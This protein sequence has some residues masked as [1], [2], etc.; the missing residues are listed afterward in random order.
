MEHVAFFRKHKYLV[1]RNLL[2]SETVAL[3]RS[4]F[5]ICRD[6]GRFS[7]DRQCPHSLSLG[8]DPGFDAVLA[9]LCPKI[10]DLTGTTLAPTYS[11]TRIYGKGE[12]LTRHR[13]RSACEISASISLEIPKGAGISPLYL[14]D[15]SSDVVEV[16]LAEGDGCIYRGMELDHW[17]EPFASAGHVQLFLHYVAKTGNYYPLR[18]Y[19]GRES[20]GAPKAERG[21]GEAANLA[22]GP[23]N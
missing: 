17:R 22:R 14:Q 2:H 13:D 3:L 16:T 12:V 7:I 23:R 6:I 18:L 20:L 19:D 9:L 15:T 11:Y 21:Q 8:H 10:S 5:R 4:Y 1:V